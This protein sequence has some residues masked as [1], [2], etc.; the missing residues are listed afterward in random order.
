MNTHLIANRRFVYRGTPQAIKQFVEALGY[1]TEDIM[2]SYNHEPVY[3]LI[4]RTNIK[5]GYKRGTDPG[6]PMVWMLNGPSLVEQHPDD[7][8]AGLTLYPKLYRRFRRIKG[9]K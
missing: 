4:R 1:Q 3:F 7:A 2:D 8:A 5:V 6:R 9:K